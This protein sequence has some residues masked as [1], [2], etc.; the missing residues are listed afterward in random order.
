MLIFPPRKPSVQAARRQRVVLNIPV[1]QKDDSPSEYNIIGK[2]L[3]F[4]PWAKE[5]DYREQIG[6]EPKVWSSVPMAV[7]VPHINWIV[8]S[9]KNAHLNCVLSFAFFIYPTNLSVTVNTTFTLF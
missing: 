6:Y 1:K 7:W 4:D 3:D 8:F 9:K 5:P 2:R